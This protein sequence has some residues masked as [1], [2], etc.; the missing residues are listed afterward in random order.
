M[1]D[2]SSAVASI[3]RAG[4]ASRLPGAGPGGVVVSPS[5]QQTTLG[6]EGA[7]AIE[8]AEQGFY[9]VRL[10]GTGDRRPF[11]V[12]VNLDPAE[13]DL[14]PLQPAEFLAGAVVGTPVTAVGQSLERPAPTPAD[15]EKRQS[16]WWFL[17]VAGLLVL[18]IETVLS[19]VQ[20]RRSGAGLRPAGS[21]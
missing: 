9:S 10:P 3:V 2:I 15:I 17:L 4:Q 8:L 21:Y 11:A 19:N 16:I 18:L 1:L 14:T 5:G 12:A 13:S 7:A 6:G 20:S